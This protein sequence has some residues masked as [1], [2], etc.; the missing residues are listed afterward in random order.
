MR[1][2]KTYALLGMAAAMSAMSDPGPVS[3]ELND[4]LSKKAPKP[5]RPPKGAKE[6]WFNAEGNHSTE[7]MRKTDIV[8]SCYAINDKNAVK[9]FNKWLN[10]KK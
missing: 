2:K 1:M 9:K 8:F 7:S 10:T 3:R 5:K 4:G 6:Y